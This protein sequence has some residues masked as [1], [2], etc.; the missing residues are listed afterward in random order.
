MNKKR[1]TVIISFLIV[2]LLTT[3]FAVNVVNLRNSRAA[4]VFMTATITDDN[5]VVDFSQGIDNAVAK[6]SYVDVGAASADSKIYDAK[7]ALKD[8]PVGVKDLSIELPIG[9][10]WVDDGASDQN[11]SAQI[12]ANRSGGIEKVALSHEKVLDYD[13]KNSGGRIYHL[14]EGTSAVSVNI[15]VKADS[16]VNT[17]YIEDALLVKLFVDNSEIETARVDVNVPS[18]VSTGGKYHVSSRKIYVMPGT[19]H[20]SY[21][22]YYRLARG[23]FVNSEYDVKRL[24]KSITY[25]MSVSDPA[26]K[27][28]LQGANDTWSIDDSDAENGNYVITKTFTSSTSG[29]LAIPYA[30]VIPED[31]EGGKV[32]QLRNTGKTTYW[33]ENGEDLTVDFASGQVISFEVLPSGESVTLNWGNLDPAE[34]SKVRNIDYSTAVRTE[35]YSQG[36]LG[37]GYV[38]N[39]GSVD[40]N[41]KTIKMSFDNSVLGVLAIEPACSP[42]GTV[43]VIHVVS[44][45]G[46]VKDTNVNKKC[47]Q[48][49]YAG[50]VT[51]VNLGLRSDDYIHE[52]QYEVGVIPAGTQIKRDANGNEG[53]AYMGRLLSD[54]APGVAQ[55][56]LFDTDNP[57]NTTGVATITTRA[58][59]GG[60]LDL[61]G[62]STQV[63]NAGESLNFSI[64]ASNWAGTT[65]YN[66]TVLSPIIYIRQQVKDA[67][68]NFLP[69]SNLKITN[70]VARGSVDITDKFGEITY[71]DTED[72]RVYKI[73]GRNVPDGLASLNT[74]YI[75]DAGG[76]YSNNGINVS[77]KIDTNLTTPDQQYNMADMVFVQDPDKTG[78]INTHNNRGDPYNVSGS[79]NN[80][81]YATTNSYYQIRGWASVGVEN[82]GKHTKSDDWLTWSEG[83]SSI[84]IG[85]AAGSL[86]D[87]KTTLTNNSGVDVA[88]PTAVYLPI[89]KKGE[90]WGALNHNSEAFEFSTALTGAI[91][92]PDASH[93]AI[94][95]GKNVTPTDNGSQIESESAKFTTDTSAWTDDDW[96]DVNCI[97]II[98][99]DIPANN[100]G[101]PDNYDFIY[102]LKVLVT[103]DASDGAVDTWRPLYF[104]Q[105]TNSVG[106]VFAGWYKGSFVSIKLADGKISGR[107]FVDANENGIKDDTEEYLNE[108]GWKIDL[109]DA[110]SNRLVQSTTTNS[111]GEYSFI[112]LSLNPNSYYATVTN[113]HPINGEGVKYLFTPKGTA[114]TI[115]DY[116]LD[117]QAE[118][119]KTTNP[120]HLT[121][122]V[123]PIS[124]SQILGE[125]TYNIGVVEY[126]ATDNYTGKVDFVD[127]N[128]KYN[129]RPDMVTITATANDGSKQ[130][131]NV[132][133]SGDGSFSADLPRY[134]SKG[135]KLSYTFS[136]PDE[137]NYDKTDSTT[138]DGHKYNVTYTQKT[139]TLTVHH[140]KRGTTEKLVDDESET[141]YWGQTYNTAQAAVD[142][143]YEYDSIDGTA[144]SV[145]A[146]DV[147]V[148]Y[149]YKL[150]RGTVIVH[151][152]FKGTTDSISADVS[153]DYDYTETYSTSPL[154]TIPAAY[155][156][157]ELVSAE[158]EGFKGTVSKPVTEV[159]YYYQKKD[160][161][162]ESE[163]TVEAPEAVDNKQAEISYKISYSATVKDYIGDVKISLVDKLPYP[164]N[165]D[166]SDLDG[167][168]Y[169]AETKT[170][171]WTMN[172]AHNTYAD[173]EEITI[174]HEIKVVYSGAQA[175]D[176]LLDTVEG[177]IELEDKDNDAADSA[178]TEVLTPSKIVFRYIGPTGAEI[179][180][181]IEDDGIVGD[182]SDVRPAEIPGYRLVEGEDI[183]YTFGEEQRI[184]IYRY[185]KI[186]NPK[187]DDVNI[188]PYFVALGSAVCLIAGFAVKRKFAH[189]RY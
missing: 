27:I 68:G 92:N 94:A 43:G 3:V 66:D 96:M 30:I 140:Y 46:V 18:G 139:A 10:V 130:T 79:A 149:Y 124:T 103:D 36:P 141:V 113:K 25:Y 20:Q 54:E 108:S 177:K 133:T 69:I 15:K 138:N 143:N 97:R 137:R 165:E 122:Y 115:D 160:A 8:L 32:Y 166:A 29:G 150:K 109:Y 42:N 14:A 188:L 85:S 169:D 89:P 170:I 155:Q 131:V 114:S 59:K 41:S 71:T 56:E 175:R 88:G 147:T 182:E 148:T 83:S 153:K 63:V 146:G 91:T 55:I 171:S 116:R 67:N 126:V 158:P 187:T 31:A 157:Y 144:S 33:Q 2:L 181:S 186:V 76:Y 117:N 6:F 134:N 64:N 121:A 101:S 172:K 151:Y 23:C 9:M 184:I 60:T 24:I 180:E 90:N 50:V 40:S 179:S 16:I 22:G 73:D 74:V 12:D 93:F 19:T 168:S 118:G 161:M 104:Q 11:L 37:V 100:P 154:E 35:K 57:S 125:A 120:A 185:E 45:S 127:Q 111:N 189:T 82:S 4:A 162:L 107:I 128:N 70:G 34:T 102:K 28:V 87:M 81:V 176:L 136:V 80:T 178:E 26:A 142:S 17:G 99:T 123:G 62:F 156:N 163:V 173:G 159:S 7:I 152:Y 75:S 53:F 135:E 78:S 52:I 58:R 77:W 39:K 98:A 1:F 48:Y 61:T 13:F 167:G 95:Y 145:V 47:S 112:E 44:A 86:A 21:E 110:S 84:T 105:L 51:G 72:A 119:S 38:N 106:D 65:R 183:D 49:G 164:I 174:E 132:A 129:T 5:G